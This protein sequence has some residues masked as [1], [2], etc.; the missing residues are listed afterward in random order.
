MMTIP[1]RQD[2]EPGQMNFSAGRP[3]AEPISGHPFK[4]DRQAI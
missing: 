3:E 2:P 1:A 4:T